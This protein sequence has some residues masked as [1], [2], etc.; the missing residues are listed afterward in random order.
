MD[1]TAEE[2]EIEAGGGFTLSRKIRAPSGARRSEPWVAS[3]VY[4]SSVRPS[5]WVMVRRAATIS[6]SGVG[7]SGGGWNEIGVLREVQGEVGS[8][9]RH[10]L[11]RLHE[12]W[13]RFSGDLIRFSWILWV[14]FKTP[15]TRMQNA[16]YV[17]LGRN[18]YFSNTLQTG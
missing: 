16:C 7:V 5:S 10:C 6:G 1:L 13:R 8:Y 15:L 12:H 3:Q 14:G 9:C 11:P 18:F 17:P 2:D 4:S